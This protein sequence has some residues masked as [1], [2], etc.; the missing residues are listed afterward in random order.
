MK[1]ILSNEIIYEVIKSSNVLHKSII[2]FMFTTGLK[3]DK[4][5]NFKIKDL[6]SA[7]SDFMDNGVS[8]D[9]LLK[10]NPLDIIPCWR[11][12]DSSKV[13]ICFNTPETTKY[14]FDYLKDRQ[15]H[16]N[17]NEESYLFKN[18]NKN[19]TALN[20]EK[21]LDKDFITKELNRKKKDLNKSHN[22]D[23]IQFNA[24]NISYTFT[25]ICNDHLKLD[26]SDKEELIALFQ[27]NTTKEN[28]FYGNQ[29]IKEYYMELVQY[30]TI[31]SIYESYHY[32]DSDDGASAEDDEK[33]NDYSD[34]V[35]K[36]KIG[37]YYM[38][39]IKTGHKLDYNE[40]DRLCGIV[41]DL[42][43]YDRDSKHHTF[44]LSDESM[45]NYFKK[46]KVQVLIQDYGDEIYILVAEDNVNVKINEIKHLIDKMGIRYTV[47]IEDNQLD[48]VLKEYLSHHTHDYGELVVNSSVINDII[49]MCIDGF[50]F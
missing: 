15:K 30:L 31:D 5:R 46:A 8:I 13:G 9:D 12:S 6:L 28:K 2:S 4:L 34:W 37:S 18:Y 35:I 14:L 19:N 1:Q 21:Q 27:A 44:I 38:N 10:K 43:I 32:P 24:S 11:I 36:Q 26:D 22:G 25:K 20:D 42:A 23:E 48:N 17:F 33:N 3:H 7:C 39:N 41:Y 29:N 49:D 40:Y 16:A 50:M 45:D 47:Y